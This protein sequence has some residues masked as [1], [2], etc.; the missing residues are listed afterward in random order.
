MLILQDIYLLSVQYRL[1]YFLKQ[2]KS[3]NKID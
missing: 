1:K 3:Y 2:K